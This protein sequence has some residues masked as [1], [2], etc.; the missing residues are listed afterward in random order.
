MALARHQFTAQDLAG[1]AVPG[2]HVEVRL[3][4][5]GQPL[6]QLYTDRAGTAGVGNP[7][8]TDPSGYV[9]FYVTGGAYQIRVYT[10]A[11]GAPTTE[12]IDRY[13]AIGL[14][15]ESDSISQRTQRVVTAAGNIVMVA[16]EA[17]EVIIE[18]AVAAPTLFT[19]CDPALRTKPVRIV[20]GKSDAATNNIA[21][22]VPVGKKLYGVLN[23][24]T[25]IDGNGGSLTLTPRADGSGWY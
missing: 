2:A 3:E 14:N 18:K 6:V 24:T 13:V 11:S 23:G 22:A 4:V 1:N 15:A 5:P 16:D 9:Y 25:T 12:H 21:I 10:G 19:C 7:I 17:D 8:D 20:D